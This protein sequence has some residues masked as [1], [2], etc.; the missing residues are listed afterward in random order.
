MATAQIFPKLTRSLISP[1]R[2]QITE[3]FTDHMHGTLTTFY[4]RDV[5]DMVFFSSLV[6]ADYISRATPPSLSRN[7]K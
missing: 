7:S 5:T 1:K 3:Q 6:K 4:S 2:I